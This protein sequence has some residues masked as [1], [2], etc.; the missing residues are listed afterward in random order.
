[1]IVSKCSLKLKTDYDIATWLERKSDTA[2]S[3]Q[4]AGYRRNGLHPGFLPPFNLLAR[5]RLLSRRGLRPQS[6]EH[7]ISTVRS[8]APKNPFARSRKR[9]VSALPGN[10]SR[11]P[12]QI[13]S[14]KIPYQ[15]FSSGGMAYHVLSFLYG[16]PPVALCVLHRN[17]PASGGTAICKGR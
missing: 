1:M 3:F 11:C 13:Q 8:L 16:Q 7:R 14:A 15:A 5:E 4:K 6:H 10:P 12:M 2:L 17:R 9:A